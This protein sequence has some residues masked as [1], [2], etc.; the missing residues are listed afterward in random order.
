HG[1]VTVFWHNGKAFGRSLSVQNEIRIP[2]YEFRKKPEIPV[3]KSEG[4]SG[5]DRHPGSDFVI[6]NSFGF[7]H[8]GFG[9]FITYISPLLQLRY[10]RQKCC[11]SRLRGALPCRAR[12][13]S[14]AAPP[15]APAR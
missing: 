14:D 12:W 6:R 15:W 8:S 11:A 5:V 10:H 3:R 13:L 2:N 4:G 9:P 7:R 1:D